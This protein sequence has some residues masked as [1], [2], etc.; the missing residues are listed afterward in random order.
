MEV[1]GILKII[2]K[3]YIVVNLAGISKY[4]VTCKM[5]DKTT[6]DS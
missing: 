5:Q 2:V 3:L 4:K 6:N 1:A